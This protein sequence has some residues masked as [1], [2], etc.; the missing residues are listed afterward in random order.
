MLTNEVMGALAL[1]ILWVNTLLVAADA[2]QQARALLR[3]R[4][5]MRALGAG[6]RGAGLVRGRVVGGALAVHRVEQVGRAGAIE[7]TILFHD[8]SACGEILGGALAEPDGGALTVEAVAVAEVWL[9]PG[10][11]ARAAACASDA[12]FDQA[13]G[14]ARKARGFSRT[15]NAT[16]GADAEVFV[17]GEA[18]G[19]G[20]GDGRALSPILVATMDPRALLARK[21][22]LAAT[23]VTVELVL[24]AACTAAALWPPVFGRISTVGGVLCLGFFLLV[25]PAGKAL[26]DALLT[27]S[28]APVRGRWTRGAGGTE[29]QAAR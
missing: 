10:E 12:A 16:V 5:E 29:P 19:A 20:H 25:Q 27:P 4:D 2:G 11:L 18:R 23:F 21:A 14:H 3:R 26:R 17:L 1:A 28:R 7:G 8:R 15:V 24:A 13:E 6:A 9:T 22:A